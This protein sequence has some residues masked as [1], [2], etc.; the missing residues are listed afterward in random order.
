[1]RVHIWAENRPLEQA[2]ERMAELYPHGIEGVLADMLSS[3]TD[4]T[5]T[6]ST[7]L[8]EEYGL[9]E[10]ILQD[11]DVLVYWSHKYWREIP[12]TYVD[13][14]QNRVLN[15]MGLVLLHSAHASKI[16]S[17]LL[18]T[19][20]QTLRWRESD[21]SQRVWVVR[22]A[23]PICSGL[24]KEYFDI[25]QDETYGEYFEIPQPDELVFLTVSSQGEVL[26]SG[27]C[28]HRGRGKIFYFSSGHETYPVYYQREV[29]LVIKNAAAWAKCTD[30]YDT[31][32]V[33][34]RKA[35]LLGGI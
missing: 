27:L 9:C 3:C 12:D 4:W 10:T 32:P 31:W 13:I 2:R 5:V 14:L 35:E 17:R 11:V 30:T 26:R 24:Q 7:S 6:T 28:Y 23:H 22:P 8:D 33:W 18:G 34:A 16:F 21:D 25:P 29:Q 20:T 1:M 19:R 15:G